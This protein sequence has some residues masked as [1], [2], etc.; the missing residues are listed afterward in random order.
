MSPFKRGTGSYRNKSKTNIHKAQHQTTRPTKVSLERI[1]L[2]VKANWPEAKILK[3]FIRNSGSHGEP[4]TLGKVPK[5]EPQE[6][7]ICVLLK[8][9]VTLLNNK[10][11][12]NPSKAQL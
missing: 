1:F 12:P 2:S 7:E 8:I 6:L 11:M 4:V 10:A 3:L 5:K 9:R